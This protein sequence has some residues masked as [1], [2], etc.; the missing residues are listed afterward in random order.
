MDA[1]TAQRWEAWKDLDGYTFQTNRAA[2]SNERTMPLFRADRSDRM[3][4][5]A[6]HILSFYVN[7][8]L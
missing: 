3:V 4:A 1:P 7:Y 6:R 5:L 8:L 2:L